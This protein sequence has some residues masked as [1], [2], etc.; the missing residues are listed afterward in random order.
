MSSNLQL[1]FAPIRTK[2]VL[3][4]V[5]ATL[6]EP[7][8]SGKFK[9]GDMLPSEEQLASQLGVGRRAVREALKVL[10]T[11]GLVQVQ[12]GVGTVVRRTDLDSFL[13]TLSR[14]VSSYLYVN[15]AQAKHVMELRLLLEGAALEHLATHPDPPRFDALLENVAKQ[16]ECLAARDFQTYQEWHFRFHYDIVDTLE[17]PVISML[18]RQVM[19]LM[20][21]SMERAGALPTRTANTIREHEQLVRETQ[22]G[23]IAEMRRVLSLHLQ[24]FFVNVQEEHDEPSSEAV[25]TPNGGS[26]IHPDGQARPEE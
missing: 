20:R 19:A 17:N 10:E 9:D 13:E 18:Y 21:A 25:E 15:R 24:R 16:H 3:E 6:E 12:M 1:G 4:T 7:I 2:R 26:A 22:Q 14:N 11:K 23:H 8:L 5:V